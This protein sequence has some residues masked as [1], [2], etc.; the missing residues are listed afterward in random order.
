MSL[1]KILNTGK[2]YRSDL[3]SGH[4]LLN[5]KGIQ[6]NLKEFISVLSVVGVLPTGKNAQVIPTTP[7][8]PRLSP[9]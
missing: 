9:I 6:L 4:R 5:S 8:I 1:F 3:V 2:E 7:S